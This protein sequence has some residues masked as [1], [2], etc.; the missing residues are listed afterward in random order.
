MPSNLFARTLC[1][2]VATGLCPAMLNAS[3]GLGWN[4]DALSVELSSIDQ[5]PAPAA[6]VVEL[7]FSDFFKLPVGPRGLELTDKIKGLEGKRVRILGFM[8]AQEKPANGLALLTPYAF[9]THE[10]EYGLCDDLPAATLFVEVPKYHG[11]AVPHTPGILLLTGR[12]ELGSK[13][14]A[15]GRVSVVRLV[16][17]AQPAAPIPATL[18]SAN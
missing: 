1:L 17:D 15:D 18:T 5:L 8:V 10:E 3:N 12:L 13:A 6:D 16:L 2:L 11:A 9:N 14:E 7:K 4:A